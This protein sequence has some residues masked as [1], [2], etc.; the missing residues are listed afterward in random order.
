MPSGAGTCAW[1]S[2]MCV[3]VTGVVWVCVCLGLHTD[4]ED[5]DLPLVT[6]Q[7]KA[8]SWGAPHRD[9]DGVLQ[10]DAQEPMAQLCQL[11]AGRDL[12]MVPTLGAK[13]T[14][15]WAKEAV[16]KEQTGGTAVC[17]INVTLI[18]ERY[19]SKMQ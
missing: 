18:F 7:D 16:G 19:T 14:G 12:A 6:Q 9:K 4:S 17:C 5:R 1:C 3:R 15:L 2:Q 11:A 10:T 13:R 8:L